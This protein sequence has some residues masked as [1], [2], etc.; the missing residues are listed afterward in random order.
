MIGVFSAAVLIGG[1]GDNET[2]NLSPE[3][4]ALWKK[5]ETLKLGDWLHDV[6][7]ARVVMQAAN[8]GDFGHPT[9]DLV[10]KLEFA[11][12]ATKLAGPRGIYDEKTSSVIYCWP[13]SGRSTTANTNHACLDAAGY[14]RSK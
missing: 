7:T 11:R 10:A 6:D 12:Q 8:N 5:V 9:P 4:A 14:K 3:A 13:E 2:A 1:C